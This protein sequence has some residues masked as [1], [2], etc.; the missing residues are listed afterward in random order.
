[1]RIYDVTV[2]LRAGMP[3]WDGEHGPRLEWQARID[4]G[5]DHDLSTFAMGSHTGTHVDAPAHYVRG[6]ATVERLPPGALVG[7]AAVVE[8][9]GSADI[10]AADLEALGVDG[11]VPRVLFKTANGRLWEQDAFQR[12]YISLT[13]GAARRVVELGLELIGIDYLSVEAYDSP[14]FAVH[15][16][17]LESGVVV[18]EGVD[19]RQVPAGEYLLVC[20]PLKL[21][22]AEGAPARVFLIDQAS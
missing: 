16:T 19:L 6:G 20:A 18:L 14:G 21:A 2:P 10:G 22:G 13:E 9:P 12:E 4:D 7:P 17:L 3:T 5:R 11:T 8:F 1:M 15:H